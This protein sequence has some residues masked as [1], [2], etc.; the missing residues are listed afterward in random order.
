MSRL[1][2]HVMQDFNGNILTDVSA[3]FRLAGTGTLATIYGDEALTVILPNPMTNHP[4]FGSIK[5]FLGVGDFDC[6]LSKPGYT[7]ETLT[8]VQGHGTMA[9]LNADYIPGNLRIDGAVGIGR[10]HDP[11]FSLAAAGA[12]YAGGTIQG[13]GNLD[14]LGTAA[15]G[16]NVTMGGSATVAA[17]LTAE[18]VAT[19]LTLSGTRMGLG[20]ARATYDGLTFRPDADAG[21]K[22]PAR[23]LNTAGVQV[24]YIDTTV[25]ATVY[26][27]SSDARLK[28]DVQD[29]TGEL[30]LITALR[31]VR[32]KW[33]A[34]NSD[35]HGFLAHEVA[36]VLA[37]VAYGAADGVDEAGQ[38]V[39]QVI[40]YSKLVPWLVGAIKTLQARIAVLEDAAG[41]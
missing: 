17:L 15:V 32:F 22:V 13:Q 12:I 24:G 8:G 1:F 33:N 5:C 2:Y 29:L 27:T 10:A 28:H 26:G 20:V 40:D 18:R 6:Y 19:G 31:P 16:G 11:S 21:A 37:G 30:A 38:I 3:T 7:F 36:Q 9:Q 14:L 4:N 34:D 23:F 25:A 41:I 39:P 35:G